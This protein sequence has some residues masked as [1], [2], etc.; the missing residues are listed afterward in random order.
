M[1][2]LNVSNNC[3]YLFTIFNRIIKT[4][5]FSILILRWLEKP[6]QKIQTISI[7]V[8][9]QNL[10]F[11][12]KH[13]FTMFTTFLIIHGGFLYITIHFNIIYA[14]IL[15]YYVNIKINI[16]CALLVITLYNWFLSNLK[17]LL[18]NRHLSYVL[19]D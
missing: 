13:C 19:N 10:L 7:T 11:R 8:F 3:R 6:R 15:S 12:L 18:L 2:F 9:L 16:Q 4:N 17:T 14:Y 5:E 1:I